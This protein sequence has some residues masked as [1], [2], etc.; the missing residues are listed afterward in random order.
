MSSIAQLDIRYVP[1]EDRILLSVTSS[2][3]EEIRLWFTR[4]ITQNVLTQLKEK[5]TAHRI[6]T[7]E[8][9][10]GAEDI[11]PEQAAAQAEFEQQ[12]VAENANFKEKFV[13]GTSFPLGEDGIVVNKINFKPD[14]GGKGNH[15]LT[16]EPKQGKGVTFGVSVSLFNTFFELM[17]RTVP[18]CEWNLTLP[19]M[20][21]LERPTS[22]TLQ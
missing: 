10:G 8:E 1:N 4:R 5:T 9:E 20:N 3:K 17:E 11:T 16:F 19:I 15:S 12:K 21:N 13:G 18:K 22:A 2:S 7:P 14:T 6:T